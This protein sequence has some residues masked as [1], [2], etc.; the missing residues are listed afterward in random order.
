MAE[1]DGDL[2]V[3]QR[4]GRLLDRGLLPAGGPAEAAER[5]I[6]RLERPARV[7][8]LGLPG[9]GKSA[10]LN[11][12]A[13]T[14]V[15]PETLRLPT[16][17]VQ[18]G[19]ESRMLCTL[20]DG[21]TQIVEGHDLSAILVLNPAMV[22]LE[23]DLPA[24]KV[25]HL[26]EVSAGP[27]EAEQRRAALWASKRA[28]ILIWCTTSYLPKEQV[29]WEAMPDVVK[30]NGFLFLTK[31]DLLGSREAAAGMLERV[32]QRAGEEF[33]QVMSISAKQARTAMQ[34][35]GGLDRD[36]FRDSGAAAVITTI[37]S[38][39]N[40]A[41]RADTDMAELLLA[42]HVEAGGIVA[43]RFAEP[44]APVKPEPVRQDEVPEWV[45]PPEV[46]AEP[47]AEVVPEPVAPEPA[48]A[49]EP[50][51]ELVPEPVVEAEPEPEPVIEL[52]PEPV[53]EAA[54]EPEPVVEPEPVI[55]P[56]P[57]PEPV[58][59][60]SPEPEPE[61]VAEAAAEPEPVVAEAPEPVEVALPEPVAEEVAAAPTGA[62]PELESVL[63]RAG[64]KKRFAD[65]MRQMPKPDEVPAGQMPVR[66][67]W[68]S[69]AETAAAATPRPAPEPRSKREPA[70]APVPEPEVIPP[71]VVEAS[72]PEPE[73]PVAKAAESG[74]DDSAIAAMLAAAGAPAV[75]RV[76][77]ER[78][79]RE[80]SRTVEEPKAE[81]VVEETPA[82]PSLFGARRPGP[83][84]SSTDRG[85]PDLSSIRA[86]P[87]EIEASE[88][89]A[90]QDAL[91]EPD[92]EPGVDEMETEAEVAEV[93]TP[94]AIQPAAEPVARFPRS[95]EPAARFRSPAPASAA[96]VAAPVAP[97]P[98]PE[99]L[100]TPRAAV[101]RERRPDADTPVRRERPRIAARAVA[102]PPPAPAA[103]MPVSAADQEVLDEA[104]QLI[105]AR[106]AALVQEIDP[107]E[108]V[109]VDTVLE[110]GRE[111]TEQVM[112]I[113]A[114]AKSGEMRR[115]NTDLG[116][117]QDLIMLM[118]LEK[119]HAPADDAMTLL[120]QIR[121]DLE[122]LRAA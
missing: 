75:D 99:Q 78:P 42:R 93:P 45:P 23:M 40:M 116:E 106:S 28:D 1:E 41:R 92:D 102:A 4:L 39:V 14:I 27:M 64:G 22:T 122:T 114:R 68:K 73:A 77:R 96:R 85:L 94:A 33:R 108:K 5:L 113:L 19:A 29:V 51:A 62:D 49:P 87:E 95:V 63:A 71:E 44:E 117:V 50:V 112:S 18:H 52:E 17:I 72:V 11:L 24:L 100:A 55:D 88:A 10:I 81:P 89:A 67:T 80:V 120:L 69:K 7:A 90:L 103:P 34:A 2:T 59:E 53:A 111:T 82:R 35:E 21:K 107:E 30:D 121:R 84:A 9:A 8:L 47:V 91:E 66:S 98:L 56:L 37:K 76:R 13:G 58:A 109:P 57:E 46:I 119:G 20:A 65:R 36:L 79:S 105:I 38:R 31:V 16:M 86:R 32:E 74:P 12:L 43:R 54:P 70:A 97:A 83:A 104:I 61:P 110:H 118:Q 15:V 3:A 26:L 48:L 6:E 60:A 25:I 101:L 115:I